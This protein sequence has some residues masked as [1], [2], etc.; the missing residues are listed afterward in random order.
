MKLLDDR[1][2]AQLP[3]K[4]PYFDGPTQNYQNQGIKC[5][6]TGGLCVGHRSFL[7]LVYLNTQIME[8]CPAKESSLEAKT[9]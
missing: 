1:Y 3:C 2:L 5:P 8:R 9:K 6:K 4:L 7:G